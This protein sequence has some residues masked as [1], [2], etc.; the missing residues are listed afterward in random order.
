MLNYQ[1]VP[2]K[3]CGLSMDQ[4]LLIPFHVLKHFVFAGQQSR[5]DLR[6]LLWRAGLGL[7]LPLWGPRDVHVPSRTEYVGPKKNEG[8]GWFYAGFMMHLQFGNN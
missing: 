4:Y 1:R 6:W 2:R 3:K 8:D 5:I 7:A